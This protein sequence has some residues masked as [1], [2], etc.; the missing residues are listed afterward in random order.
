MI[1][2]KPAFIMV[3][4]LVNIFCAVVNFASLHKL[5]IRNKSDKDTLDYGYPTH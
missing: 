4:S 3:N 2:Y 1:G 5:I